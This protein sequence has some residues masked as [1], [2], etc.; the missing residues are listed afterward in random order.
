[1]ALITLPSLFIFAQATL[2]P[3]DPASFEMPPMTSGA[4]VRPMARSVK[5]HRL[6]GSPTPAPSPQVRISIINATSVPSIGLTMTSTNL[7][8]TYP[9]FPQGIWTA[10]APLKTPLIHFLVHGRDGSIVADRPLVFQPVSSVFLLLTGDL[11]TSGPPDQPPQLGLPLAP[12]AKPWPPNLQFHIYPSVTGTNEGCCY[13]VFNGMPSKLLILKTPAEP[14]KPSRQLALLAPGN[15]ALFIHQPSNLEWEA[16]IEGQT[17]AV[18]IEQ[19]GEHRNCLI[20]FFLKDGEPEFI[21]V[22]EDSP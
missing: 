13:R 15:S 21:R 10:D 1:M 8:V 22:F 4:D 19:E 11:S 14:D 5:E 6:H 2:A 9:D 12:G 7:S 16:E 17:Y 18:A 20:P 3:I